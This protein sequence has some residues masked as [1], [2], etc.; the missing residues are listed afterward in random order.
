MQQLPAALGAESSPKQVV[1]GLEPSTPI[2]EG[3]ARPTV[4]R[5]SPAVCRSTA[6]TPR[7]AWATAG[8]S[9]SLDP[10]SETKKAT[11]RAPA[12][13]SA[14]LRPLA[15]PND[16]DVTDPGLCLSGRNPGVLPARSGRWNVALTLLCFHSFSS[17]HGFAMH[18]CTPRRKRRHTRGDAG[19]RARTRTL[20]DLPRQDLGTL[21]IFVLCQ[22]GLLITL[23]YF[24]SL[25]PPF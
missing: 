6:S 1:V 5:L 24:L 14:V 13:L 3:K 21:A 20:L 2:N 16:K 23:F 11:Q 19:T 4:F 22:K 25:F 9:V 10:H 18:K 17:L 7:R 15:R 8:K 12:S